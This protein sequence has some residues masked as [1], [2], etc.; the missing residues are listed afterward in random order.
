MQ[1]FFLDTTISQITDMNRLAFID[2]KAKPKT[3]KYI[4]QN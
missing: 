2:L 3:Y 1:S 4:K